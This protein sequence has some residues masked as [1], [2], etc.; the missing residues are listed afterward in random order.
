MFNYALI[1]ARLAKATPSDHVESKDLEA[2]TEVANA[3]CAF[4][5]TSVRDSLQAHAVQLHDALTGTKL[6]HL[7]LL[8][9]PL[10]FRG[11]AERA[12]GPK[13]FKVRK[14]P[15]A[16]ECRRAK[17]RPAAHQGAVVYLFKR[18]LL[19][20]RE[21]SKRKQDQPLQCTVLGKVHCCCPFLPKHLHTSV[22]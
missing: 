17:L 10:V 18:H 11:E 2:A 4:V 14:A 19:V 21:K 3:T 22:H 5:N 12:D 20:I 7:D 6:T 1:L 16:G 15:S 8:L 9:E 13:D